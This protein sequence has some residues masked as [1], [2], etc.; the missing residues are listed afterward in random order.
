MLFRSMNA[1]RLL[2][3]DLR[4]SHIIE[5]GTFEGGLTSFMSDVA[6]SINSETRIISYDID[7]IK[8]VQQINNAEI[9]QLDI[10]QIEQYLRQNHDMI[11]ALTGPK[12]II[13]DIGEDS[14]RL[15]S[16]LDPYVNPGDYFVSCG[17][18]NEELHRSLMD[19]AADEY[20]IDTYYC[21]MFG[22]NFIENPN[23]FLVKTKK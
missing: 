7:V 1:L 5:F 14:A 8:I 9:V 3:C 19:A 2:I 16:V 6:A 13:D 22:E 15:L 23:G 10:H 20:A 21:D 18:L 17:T 4:P 12:I 11:V